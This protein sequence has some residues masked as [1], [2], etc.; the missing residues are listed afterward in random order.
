MLRSFRRKCLRQKAP[1]SLNFSFTRAQ[2]RHGQAAVRTG[3]L[4]AIG[5]IG[6]AHLVLMSA[7]RNM[8]HK[9]II[10]KSALN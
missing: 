7:G 9:L 5:V 3:K 4:E 8:L 6:H 10:D 1:I 2:K